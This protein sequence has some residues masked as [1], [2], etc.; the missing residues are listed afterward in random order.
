MASNRLATSETEHRFS[1]PGVLGSERLQASCDV[2]LSERL[3]RI[4]APVLLA[5]LM[6]SRPGAVLLCEIESFADRLGSRVY[7]SLQ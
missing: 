6:P 5:W 4:S 1:L 2:S 7:R 3:D